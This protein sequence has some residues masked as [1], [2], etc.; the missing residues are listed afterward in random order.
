MATLSE[1][2]TADPS[3]HRQGLT[4]RLDTLRKN[5]TFCDVT[6]TVKGTEFKAHKVVLAAASPFFLSL[7]ESNM[8]ESN[9][10]VIRIELEEATVPLMEDVLKYGYTGNVSVT[11]ESGHNLIATSDYPLLPGLKT[12]AGNFMKENVTIDNCVFNY[13]FADKYHC[14]ELKVTS[15]EM[16][17]SNFSVVMETDDFLNLDVKQ[18]MEWVS[19]DDIT[20]SA[21]EQVFK[22][23]VKWVTHNKGERESDFRDLLRQV[24]LMSISH[25]FLFNELVKEELVTTNNE[26]VNFVLQSMEFICSSTDESCTKPPRKCLEMHKDTKM[27]SLFV[28]EHKPCVTFP[29]KIHGTS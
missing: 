29:R 22:G 25:D 21:E 23:I 17:N 12:V 24:R 7:L 6:V 20:V 16:I 28:V 4:K 14:E 18:V 3:Q 1:P 5:E 26:C 8:R 19:S 15:Y 13:Y 2:M 27:Q 9:E 11:E 10:Q